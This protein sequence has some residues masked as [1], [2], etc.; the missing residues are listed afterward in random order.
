M[1][2]KYLL[3]AGIALLMSPTAEHTYP[4]ETVLCE[5]VGGLNVPE[6]YRNIKFEWTG[7]KLTSTGGIIQGP[8]HKETWYNLDMERVVSNMRKLGYSEELY[9]YWVRGDGV[10]MLGDYAIV[11][12][13]LINHPRG[14]IVQTSLGEGIVCDTGETPMKED[15][16]DIATNW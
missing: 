1:V 5:P 4:V 8:T 6:E 2:K 3:L 9:P 12:A 7:D 14:I 16:Y 11:A 13:N 10:K 15:I